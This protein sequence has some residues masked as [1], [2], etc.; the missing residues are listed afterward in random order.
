MYHTIYSLDWVVRHF[1]FKNIAQLFIKFTNSFVAIELLTFCNNEKKLFY[2]SRE[3]SVFRTYVNRIDF[4]AFCSYKNVSQN[5]WFCI[6]MK[7]MMTAIIERQSAQIYTQKVKKMRNVFIYKKPDTFQK[8]NNF[9]YVLC[10]KAIHLTLRY[11]HEILKLAFIYKKHDTL[12][13]V[14]FLNTKR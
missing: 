13:Y 7:I 6:W 12:R 5:N 4:F 10:T 1:C 14:K 3:L 8:L 2:C 9:R 11:F